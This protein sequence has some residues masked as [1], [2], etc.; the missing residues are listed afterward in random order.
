MRGS[1]IFLQD[2]KEKF[3][4]KYCPLEFLKFFYHLHIFKVLRVHTVYEKIR[5]RSLEENYL[6][7]V[8]TYFILFFLKE[9][10]IHT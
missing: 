8:K 6:K 7:W 1:Q 9:G 3:L 4:Q 10:H 5:C 2:V